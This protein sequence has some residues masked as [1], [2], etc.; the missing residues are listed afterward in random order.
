MGHI[1]EHPPTHHLPTYRHTYAHAYRHQYRYIQHTYMGYRTK[2]Q[3]TDLD[4]ALQKGSADAQLHFCIISKTNDEQDINR[5]A[6][7]HGIQLCAKQT[8]NNS[9]CARHA[10]VRKKETPEARWNRCVCNSRHVDVSKKENRLP[11]RTSCACVCVAAVHND[12]CQLVLR[13]PRPLLH[14]HT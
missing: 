6:C 12:A 14:R 13:L 7:V 8:T 1:H 3:T 2:N 11:V 5:C 9:V 10:I 4:H